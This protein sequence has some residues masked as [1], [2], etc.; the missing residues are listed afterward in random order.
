MVH[1]TELWLHGAMHEIRRAAPLLL[2]S[3][4]ASAF[5]AT[6]ALAETYEVG[7]GMP[8]TAIG[9]V[10]WESLM[11]GD[12][13]RIHH[14]A[15]PYNEK[16]V[17]GRRGT[18]A[19]PII[20]QGVPGAGGELPIIDGRDATTRSALRYTN[21]SR[22]V[23]KVGSSDT[24]ADTLPAWIVIENLDVRSGRAP[25]SFE[26]PGG[27]SDTYSDNAAAIY[28]EKA[29]HLVIRNCILRDSGNGL[30]I[31]A[32][33]GQTQNVLIEGNWIHDNGIE[34]SVYQ[35][36][37]YT[38]A[39]D[40]VFQH[41]HYG[42]LRTG[43]D[44]NNLKDRSAGLVVRYNWIESGNRQLDLVDAEDSAVLVAH[45]RYHETFVYGN[46][47][48]EH[49]GDGNSQMVHYGGDSGTEAD[50]RKG[51][52]HFFNN[53]VVS[54][55]DGNTTLV[56]LSTYE[57]AADVRNNVVYVTTDGG[58]L[59]ML[60]RSGTLRLS[61]N[62]MKAGWVDSHDTFG[63]SITDDGTGITGSVPGFTDEAGQDYHLAD[64]SDCIDAATDLLA[65]VLPAHDVAMQYVRH[66]IA[67]ARP[68][69]G[70]LDVGAFEWCAPGACAPRPDA[71]VPP[72]DGGGPGTDGG[73]P[74]T[75][76]GGPG[77]DGSTT[78]RDGGPGATAGEDGGCGCEAVGR[79]EPRWGLAL[80]LGLLFATRL[81]RRRRRGPPR[82]RR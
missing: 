32:F 54:T 36:N 82:C 8:Y 49:E 69:D 67:E 59:A 62:W 42:P 78:G 79:G 6:P 61:H 81:R 46:V 37:S 30:F 44:G 14:R 28:V 75:D 34:G 26:G 47:L 52:L 22:G 7:D 18:E 45:P 10:P 41:N 24:P 56:R 70:A 9:D 63:G 11:P 48:A 38:A 64:G 35:H 3:L 23:I 72:S 33:D 80:A 73:G 76:G 55:R 65:A 51:T 17:I 1:G 58:R 60:S 27:G 53:T 57:E 40:I 31:G 25:F 5:L 15:S 13:V 66:Q 21:Q 68:F 29:E 20:I 4:A 19:A 12:I 77:T 2:A 50:Y 43:C 74:G 16:W 39:I 71:G